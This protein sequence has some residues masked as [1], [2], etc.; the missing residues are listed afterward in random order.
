M[1][2]RA[3]LQASVGRRSIDAELE[4]DGTLVVIGPNGAGKTSLLRLLLGERPVSSGRIEAGTDVL[5]DT[6]RGIDVPLER[7]GLAYV[8]QDYALFPHLTVRQNVEFALV[9]AGA[10]DRGERIRTALRE[11]ALE[12]LAE[13]RPHTLSGGE[14]Q[15]VA[16]ARA[17][18][19]R[20]RALLLDEPLAAL[21]VHSR[22]GVRDFL[23]AYLA[24]VGLPSV[25]VT[26]DAEDARVLGARIAVLEEGRVTQAGT[27]DEIASRPRSAFVEEFVGRG[28]GEVGPR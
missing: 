14:K 1:T 3:R 27:W 7:R 9:S 17:I 25:V 13:R 16:L 21:D 4:T 23:A 15:R 18:S 8:P 26:H 11:L 2:L 19:I 20:P 6:D 28:S 24:R 22:R 12:A 5:L 10:A